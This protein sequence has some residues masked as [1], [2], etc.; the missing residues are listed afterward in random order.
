MRKASKKTLRELTIVLPLPK[1]G[2]SAQPSG[3]WRSKRGDIA[4][5]RSAAKAVCESAMKAGGV[6]GFPKAT[7]TIRL[8][9][10]AKK[11]RAQKAYI[12]RDDGNAIQAVKA[13]ID[14]CVDAG[15]LPDDSHKFLKL[16]EFPAVVIFPSKESCGRAETVITF[17][18]AS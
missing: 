4:E 12:P 11:A 6:S 16:G 7:Y 5:G 1:R 9:C 18:E 2:M 17:K 10:D 15:L 13:Y 8:F 3:G 14:G